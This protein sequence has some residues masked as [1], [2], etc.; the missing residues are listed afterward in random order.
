LMVWSSLSKAPPP[1]IIT[2]SRCSPSNSGRGRMQKCP[3]KFTE[4]LMFEFK[5]LRGSLCSADVPNQSPSTA[6]DARRVVC[7]CVV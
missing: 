3:R 2:G 4:V 5:Y 1:T 7:L 6:F